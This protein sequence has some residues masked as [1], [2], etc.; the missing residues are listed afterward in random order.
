MPMPIPVSEFA[1]V[2]ASPLYGKTEFYCRFE[3][4]WRLETRTR[5]YDVLTDDSG[6]V[7]EITCDELP[8]EIGRL[9][10]QHW[11]LEG[12]LVTRTVAGLA[13]RIKKAVPATAPS[14]GSE[15]LHPAEEEVL[16]AIQTIAGNTNDW[17]DVGLFAHGFHK[18]L[19]VTLDSLESKGYIQCSP[20]RKAVRL[21]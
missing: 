11:N 5:A 8:C 12:H 20:L 6:C 10:L 3:N 4:H 2:L 18:N 1:E 19:S 13:P 15:A 7:I 14:F 9:I 21:R 17:V 16:Q